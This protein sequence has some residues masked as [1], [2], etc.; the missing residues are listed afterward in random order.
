[1]KLFI[2]L[3][4]VLMAM[5][6][7]SKACKIDVIKEPPRDENGNIIHKEDNGII[8]I[9]KSLTPLGRGVC[10]IIAANYFL[11]LNLITYNG[12]PTGDFVVNLIAF[13]IGEIIGFIIMFYII[14]GIMSLVNANGSDV[15]SRRNTAGW[16]NVGLS[17]LF[18][19]VAVNQ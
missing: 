4:M 15:T 18:T 11:S 12:Q 6:V 1:M 7:C 19:F 17:I 8:D 16:I 5:F 14:Y 13:S 9:L 10:L 2:M 3:F